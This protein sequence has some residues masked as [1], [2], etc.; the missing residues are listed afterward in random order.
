MARGR[1]C[2]YVPFVYP[3]FSGGALTF[4]GGIEVQLS[5]LARGLARRGFEVDV[6]TCDYGQP[7]EVSVDGVRLLRSWRPAAG[8]PVLRFFHPRLTR[9][10]SALRASRADVYVV[11]GAGMNAGLVLDVARAAGARFLFLAGHD[12]DVDAALPQVHGPR[13]R[14]WTRRALRRAD[15]LVAQTEKQRALLER[16]F[17]RASTVIMNPVDIPAG[18]ADPGANRSVL[19][20]ATYKAAK[21]PEWFT[22]F[23]GR[24]PELRCVMAGV[25]PVPPLDDR[26]YRAAL[27]VAARCPNLEVRGPIPHER[28]GELLVQGAVFTHTS[29]A[30]GFPNAF[31][32]AWSHGLPTLTGFDPDGI[33]AR[34]RLG[35]RHGTFEAWE[36]AVVRWMADPAL[37]R[38][39]G[40]RARE[41]ARLH[42]GS[43]EIHD[44]FAALLDQLVAQR[45]R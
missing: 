36:D 18:Q 30:E 39:A 33:I 28:I 20:L 40:A 15:A 16:N 44:R 21:R 10:V 25:I 4:T 34:E 7:P 6:V 43:G 8:L 17:G 14:W 45:R 32:E 11:Q 27:A 22:R 1:V 5:L 2:F 12:D 3:L 31:L 29:P 9:A 38:E 13:D 41:Y 24:H 37:R 35:E 26:E 42:H 19:W 23:A